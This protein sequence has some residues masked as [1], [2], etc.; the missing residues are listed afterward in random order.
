MQ[1]ARVAATPLQT[2]DCVAQNGVDETMRQEVAEVHSQCDVTDSSSRTDVMRSK[3]GTQ[4]EG[5]SR[6]Q[7]EDVVEL[8]VLLQFGVDF[9]S[10]LRECH[11]SRIVNTT[12]T[13]RSGQ[14][15]IG[16]EEREH[17]QRELARW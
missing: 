8:Q 15:N 1:G 12:Q 9:A 3:E 6:L 11:T 4:L 7:V 13:R 14:Q 17:L 16:L 5:V 10:E 2:E